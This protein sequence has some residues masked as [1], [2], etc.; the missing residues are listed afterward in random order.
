MRRLDK[1]DD[2][3]RD[4]LLGQL[5]AIDFRLLDSL[6]ALIARAPDKAAAPSL[7]PP[8]LFPLHRNLEQDRQAKEATELGASLLSKGQVGFV[9][10]AGGQASRLGYDGPKGA[11]PTGP[12]TERTLFGYHAHRLRACQAKYGKPTPW[13]IMTSPANDGTTRTFFEQNEF[14]GLAPDDVHFF[15]QE[16]LPALDEEGQIL[17]SAPDSLFLAPN[18]HGGV[19]SGLRRSG[20]LDDMARRGVEQLSYFQVDNPLVRPADPLFLGLHVGAGA[21][22]SSKVVSKRNPDEK[23]GVLGRIDGRMGC[24]EYSDLPESLREA[25][26]E[27]GQLSFRAGNIAVHV[28]RREFA[29]RVS[30]GSLELP[31][32]V[33][34]KTMKVVDEDGESVER[35]GFKF[36]TFVFDALAES[37]V[38][39]TL[40]VDRSQEFSPIKNRVG[41]DSPETS[42]ADLSKLFSDWVT[43]AG[44]VLPDPG[45]GGEV[46]VEVDPLFAETEE[47]F[48]ARGR[49]EPQVS[50]HGHLYA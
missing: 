31:W 47:E 39:V 46:R 30:S 43:A 15:Q 36:E 17:F 27:D 16:M 44:L 5:Q 18:G 13:Y 48:L 41:E 2:P 1:L 4:R 26:G 24:I 8:E 12:V 33:A 3:S 50:E 28:L 25:K 10:V 32:H 14:F 42:R 20:M 19:L 37:P 21:D 11:F 40:E 23:V 22:M 35:T 9:L 38:S 29:E 49:P 6:R 34:K 7:D 45:E